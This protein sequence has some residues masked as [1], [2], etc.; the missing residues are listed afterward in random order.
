MVYVRT[1]YHRPK[2][3]NHSFDGYKLASAGALDMRLYVLVLLCLLIPS[4]RAQA[5]WDL[6]DSHTTASLRGIHNVSG[7]VAWASGSKG[8]VLRT[9]DGGYLWQTCAVPPGA[10]QLDFRGI[11]AFDANTA[12]VMSSGTGDLSRLYKT[13][14]GCKTWKLVF[15]NP[16][17]EGFW[18]AILLRIQPAA[19]PAKYT[20][21]ILGDPINGSFVEFYTRDNG[22]HWVRQTGGQAGMPS[23]KDGESLFAASN[24]CL[25]VGQEW[26]EL[27]VT[28]G[29]PGSRS[30]VLSEF[31]KHDPRVS[32]KYVGG[33]IPLATGESAGAFSVALASSDDESPNTLP[34]DKWTL[35]YSPKGV[36]VAVGGDY[37]K[38]DNS[39][40]TAAF[41]FDS[42]LHWSQAKTSPH[43]YRSAVAYDSMSKTWITVG[44]NG[45]DIS[46]DD[47]RNWRA[48]KPKSGQP[49]D[50]DKNWNALSLPFVVGANGRIG[51]LRADALK[52]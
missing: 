48:L 11:Q 2:H 24:S 50:A 4:L 1:M 41:S 44:P 27:F 33:S 37:K 7:G 49:V 47:G 18:D 40:G 13:T 6:Q 46:T 23:A 28:G 45:T 8:T 15:T 25:I 16:D 31:V 39:H 43:G 52:P 36:Y 14:D 19:A 30:R 26:V 51:K 42:G 5:Q 17:P 10:E 20:G 32:W 9:E 3:M 35:L 12:V 21:A 34:K 29:S 38:P 22:D